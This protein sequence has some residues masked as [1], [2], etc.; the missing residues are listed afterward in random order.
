[1]AFTTE[2]TWAMDLV[3]DQLATGGKLQVLTIIDTFSRFSLAIA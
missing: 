2:S 3:H 1:L